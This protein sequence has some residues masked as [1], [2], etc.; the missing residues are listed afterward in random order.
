M[1]VLI[2]LGLALSAAF[3]SLLLTVTAIVVAPQVIAFLGLTHYSGGIDRARD[4]SVLRPPVRYLTVPMAIGIVVVV[5]TSI[6]AI[7]SS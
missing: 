5:L 2:G 3:G 6:A 7:V 4:E 1:L